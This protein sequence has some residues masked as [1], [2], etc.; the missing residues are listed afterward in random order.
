MASPNVTFRRVMI[1]VVVVL[2][3]LALLPHR[4]SGYGS[5]L[6]SVT[7]TLLSVVS[8]PMNSLSSALRQRY[9]QPELGT[10]QELS[11]RVLELR[12]QVMALEQRERD[13]ERAVAELQG[14]RR[15]QGDSYVH[16]RA[17]V[18]GRGS[19]PAGGMLQLNIGTRHGLRVGMP[20]VQGASVVGRITQAGPTS[21][22]LGLLTTPGSLVEV[23]TV[24]EGPGATG[25][26]RARLLLEATAGPQLIANQVDRQLPTEAGDFARLMD[27]TWPE[28][29]QGMLVGR[30]VAVEEDADD[31]LLK[32]VGVRPLR[33]LRDL[34]SVIVIVPRDMTE[35]AT[36]ELELGQGSVGEGVR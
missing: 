21:S 10:E 6:N 7:G 18:V 11:E 24:S 25:G 17:A 27:E 12:G 33:S 4:Y 13:L 34:D 16:R 29:V 28:S 31:P 15:R 3:V 19:D 5:L 35:E 30:V 22:T 23:V 1:A 14:L 26:R 9:D 2:F 32:R 20:A 8:K 36:P